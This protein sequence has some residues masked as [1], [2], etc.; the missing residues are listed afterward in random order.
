MLVGNIEKKVAKPV[1]E[2]SDHND[3]DPPLGWRWVHKKGE[4]QFFSLKI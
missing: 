1:N 2:F 3:P 4:E